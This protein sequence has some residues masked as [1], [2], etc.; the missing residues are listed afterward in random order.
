[1]LTSAVQHGPTNS[2]PPSPGRTFRFSSDFWLLFGSLVRQLGR[3]SDLGGDALLSA[4]IPEAR[5]L[6][7][8]P[9]RDY[10]QGIWSTEA[11]PMQT[12]RGLIKK[13]EGPES[14][15]ACL[16]CGSWIPTSP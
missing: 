13:I 11:T 16:I 2:P 5:G 4:R 3:G 9:L 8:V 6:S 14:Y 15:A 10:E 12:L 1:M 7:G